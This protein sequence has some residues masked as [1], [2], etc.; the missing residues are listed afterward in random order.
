MSKLINGT[1]KRAEMRE[2]EAWAR[3]YS[4]ALGKNEMSLKVGDPVDEYETTW[5]E[6]D[7]Q[8]VQK[9]LADTETVKKVLDERLKK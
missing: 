7:E 9:A 3:I 2:A 4:R 6:E 1:D 5:T 8:A